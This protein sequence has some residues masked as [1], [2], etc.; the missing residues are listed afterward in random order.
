MNMNKFLAFL[1]GAAAGAAIVWLTTTEEGK[2]KVEEIKK[3]A[4]QGLDDLENA[5]GNLKDKA[6]ASAKA[7]VETVEEAIN[8]KK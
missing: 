8:K 6:E 5:V 4:T 2:E 1:A 7:A 3:K